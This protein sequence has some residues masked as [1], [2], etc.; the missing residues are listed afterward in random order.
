[1]AKK[2]DSKEGTVVP[3]DRGESQYRQVRYFDASRLQW[4]E[5]TIMIHTVN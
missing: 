3:N 1:M 5:C 4:S 2:H